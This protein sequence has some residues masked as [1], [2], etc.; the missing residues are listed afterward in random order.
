VGKWIQTVLA[1]LVITLMTGTTVAQ[2]SATSYV[3]ARRILEPGMSGH[4]VERLQDRLAQLTYYPGRARGVFNQATLEAVWAFQEVQGIQVTGLVAVH[5]ERALVRPLTPSPFVRRGGALRVEIN[6]GRH[7][8]FVYHRNRVVLI[9]HVSTGGGY[10]YCSAGSCSTAITPT[11]NFR[12]TFRISGWD[13]APLGMMYN[14]VYFFSDYAIHGDLDVPLLPVSHGCVRV[15]M[16]VARIFPSLVPGPGI[17][18]YIR[19]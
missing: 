17:P 15:P 18:V 3:P 1:G 12:T 8:L 7:V 16:D 6:L 19:K 14:P 2:A 10:Y 13:H 4:D 5:T 9:S 11:G